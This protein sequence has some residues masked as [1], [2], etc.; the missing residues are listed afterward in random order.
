MT[1]KVKT[2]A[3]TI[4]RLINE[5]E[6]LSTSNFSSVS[7]LAT[8]LSPI[9]GT[10][11]VKF[12]VLNSLVGGLSKTVFTTKASNRTLKSRLLSALIDRKFA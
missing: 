5:V 6:N 12:K 7:N 4:A 3:Y 11:S 1:I 9:A 2:K 8:A 10:R